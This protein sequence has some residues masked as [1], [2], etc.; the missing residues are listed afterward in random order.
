MIM[1]EFLL[2]P[3][4]SHEYCGAREAEMREPAAGE[5]GSP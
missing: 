2:L 5:V 3:R 4:Q 1:A